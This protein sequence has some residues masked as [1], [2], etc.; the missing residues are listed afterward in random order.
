MGKGLIGLPKNGSK[1]RD[2]NNYLKWGGM[3]EKVEE[4]H[5]EGTI[6]NSWK[7]KNGFVKK[8]RKKKK[9]NELIHL[10]N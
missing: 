2:T 4:G 9:E 7:G 3:S 8:R 1:G 6:R 5:K 10:K